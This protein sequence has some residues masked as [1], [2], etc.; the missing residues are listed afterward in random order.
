MP[1][2][3]TKLKYSYTDSLSQNGAKTFEN[4]SDSVTNV[5]AQTFGEALE[6]ND[7]FPGGISEITKIEK[8]TT[9]T[10][11]IPVA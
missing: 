4:I 7:V 2:T 3:A 1:T 9:T 11:E 8:I 6:H 10:T 5:Q